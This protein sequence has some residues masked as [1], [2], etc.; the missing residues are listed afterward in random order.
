VQP[1]VI[2]TDGRGLKVSPKITASSI[3]IPESEEPSP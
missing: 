3:I 2:L 1:R